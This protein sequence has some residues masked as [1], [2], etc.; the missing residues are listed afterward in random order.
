VFSNTSIYK[1]F[2]HLGLIATAR[3]HSNA[4]LASTRF[5]SWTGA[6][7]IGR[8][9]VLGGGTAHGI[10]LALNV[11]VI[12][13]PIHSMLLTMSSWC[14]LLCIECAEFCSMVIG[15]CLVNLAIGSIYGA[16]LYPR[17]WSVFHV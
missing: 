5:P 9:A 14:F 13:L 16:V 11:Y 15:P 3:R 8:E 12:P 2:S 7:S 4:L 17:N 6:T 10:V 1:C